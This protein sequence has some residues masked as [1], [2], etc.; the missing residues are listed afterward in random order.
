MIEGSDF[1]GLDSPEYQKVELLR[2]MISQAVLTQAVDPQV[3]LK[4]EH[5]NA[6]KAVK[7]QFPWLDD[8]TIQWDTEWNV[9]HK[10]TTYYIE[11]K[12]S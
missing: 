1:E 11:V 8:D 4:T 6:L 10:I 12:R 2:R 7:K 5:L 9:N 3:I